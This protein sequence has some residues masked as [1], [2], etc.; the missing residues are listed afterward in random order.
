MPNP[1]GALAAV[2]A[3]LQLVGRE[4]RPDDTDARRIARAD[5]LERE[6]DLMKLVPENLTLP[7]DEPAE[8]RIPGIREDA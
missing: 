6:A 4:P 5:L 1:R 7:L 2:R 8:L 3:R